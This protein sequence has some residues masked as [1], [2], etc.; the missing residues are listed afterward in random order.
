[1]WED[2][3]RNVRYAAARQE[4]E[5]VI[6]VDY[7]I[8]VPRS[9]K[10]KGFKRESIGGLED[11]LIPPNCVT[12]LVTSM[13]LVCFSAHAGGITSTFNPQHLTHLVSFGAQHPQASSDV[14]SAF[15]D[16]RPKTV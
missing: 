16:S 15:S 2:G 13:E 3:R 8:P 7:E 1:M 11:W 6:V 5:V 9:D 10:M 4:V 12:K 14:T